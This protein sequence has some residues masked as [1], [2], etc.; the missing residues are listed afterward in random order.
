MGESRS[1]V[2]SPGS[3]EPRR[4]AGPAAMGHP[5]WGSSMGF[6]LST[7]EMGSIGPCPLDRPSTARRGE[8]PSVPLWGPRQA[9]GFPPTG[10]ASAGEVW[11]SFGFMLTLPEGQC[12]ILLTSTGYRERVF[13]YLVHA[14]KRSQVPRGGWM[15]LR[16]AQPPS[17]SEDSSR[18][19]VICVCLLG[20]ALASAFV[21]VG[22]FLPR[23]CI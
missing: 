15:P 6:T 20:D 4:E 12:R 2:F 23:W 21:R 17:C 10:S 19:V 8:G 13:A 7:S 5:P 11:R 1:P 9:A 18:L 3:M 16:W 14:G 22:G